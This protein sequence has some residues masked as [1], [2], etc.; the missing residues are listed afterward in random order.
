MKIPG[1]IISKILNA[2]RIVFFTG[3]GISAESGVPA[4]KKNS[5]GL[6]AECSPPGNC[7][8]GELSPGCKSYYAEY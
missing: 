8:N 2:E 7:G 6:R 3:A 1:E 4:Q 5:A